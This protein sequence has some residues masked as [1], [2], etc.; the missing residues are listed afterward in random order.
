MHT[1]I[2]SH[3]HSKIQDKSTN[4]LNNTKFYFKKNIKHY[5]PALCMVTG[6]SMRLPDAPGE[7]TKGIQGLSY[8]KL[9]SNSKYFI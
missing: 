1:F 9:N 6:F 3:F 7:F 2:S 8:R 5:P 4:F